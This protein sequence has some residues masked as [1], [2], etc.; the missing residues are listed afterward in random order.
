[1]PSS[2]VHYQQ[3]MATCR[4]GLT[5]FLQ[6][7]GHHVGI[8]MRQYQPHR[9]I[10]CWAHRPED[11]VRLRLL[12]AHDTRA[13]ALVRS[14]PGLGAALAN[15]HF[16]LKPDLDLIERHVRRQDRLNFLG[17]IF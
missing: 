9:S 5:D 17:K 14:N 4:N 12:L 7:Q 15:A 11:I 1:M 10:A 13:T 2:L 3:G 16:I 6:M 8:G